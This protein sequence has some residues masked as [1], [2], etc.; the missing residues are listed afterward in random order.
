MSMAAG[1]VI[2]GS[3]ANSDTSKPGAA[4]SVFSSASGDSWA[5]AMRGRQ[6]TDSASQGKTQNAHR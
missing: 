2:I 5:C 6:R 1:L 3:V 4:L